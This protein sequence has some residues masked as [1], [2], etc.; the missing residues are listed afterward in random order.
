[1]KVV[2][3]SVIPSQRLVQLQP[4]IRHPMLDV[5][6]QLQHGTVLLCCSVDLCVAV[7]QV[8]GDMNKGEYFSF[9]SINFPSHK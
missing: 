8:D 5:V 4:R 9:E 6:H 2:R 3:E 7:Y 1:M